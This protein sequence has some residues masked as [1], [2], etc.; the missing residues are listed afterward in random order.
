MILITLM[1]VLVLV[2]AGAVWHMSRPGPA[3]VSSGKTPAASNDAIVQ[4]VVPRA[5]PMVREG[6]NPFALPPQYLPPETVAR[7]ADNAIPTATASASDGAYS[8]VPP[9]PS[10][11]PLPASHRQPSAGTAR[12]PEA[13]YILRGVVSGDNGRQTAIIEH[14]GQSRSYRRGE[15]VGSYLLTEIDTSQAVLDGPE[16][17]LVLSLR[18]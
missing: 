15:L 3:Q 16:G 4:P 12:S 1:V 2:L 8:P 9:A 14:D 17:R 5:A 10:A 13:G 18:R 6:R 7:T 11:S